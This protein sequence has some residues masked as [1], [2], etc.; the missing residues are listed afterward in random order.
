MK[1]LTL[2]S[3]RNKLDKKPW[4]AKLGLIE[5]DGKVALTY[6][7]QRPDDF[8]KVSGTK[9]DYTWELE[10]NVVYAKGD[11]YNYS[12][13]YVTNFI[14]ENGVE[15]ELTKAQAKALLKQAK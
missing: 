8:A 7:F 14:I 15:R 11:T 10:E 13:Y 5:T 4:L 9:N 3:C 2:T 1:T 12:K 6:T